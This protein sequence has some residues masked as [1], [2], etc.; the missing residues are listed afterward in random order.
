VNPADEALVD[1]ALEMLATERFD[2]ERFE[3]AVLQDADPTL[4]GV[5]D[6]NDHDF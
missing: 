1:V 6:V 2:F 5:G 4:L 3:R